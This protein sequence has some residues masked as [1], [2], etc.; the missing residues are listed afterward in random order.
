MTG[1]QT[2]ALPIYFPEDFIEESCVSGNQRFITTRAMPVAVM[3]ELLGNE[4]KA[5][6]A[7]KEVQSC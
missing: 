2:C 1:V 3:F 5:F 6:F 7:G 4:K